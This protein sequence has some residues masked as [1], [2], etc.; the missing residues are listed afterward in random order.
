M[1]RKLR[2]FVRDSIRFRGEMV[3]C[4]VLSS[5]SFVVRFFFDDTV[6]EESGCGGYSKDAL[7]VM[8]FEEYLVRCEG[9]RFEHEGTEEDEHVAADIVNVEILF[10]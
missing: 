4:N 9:Y 1:N 6:C 3:K 7:H 8:V 2:L 10:L 5:G